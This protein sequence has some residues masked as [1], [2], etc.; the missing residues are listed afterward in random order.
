MRSDRGIA[1]LL[2]PSTA[3]ATA[4]DPTIRRCRGFA[5]LWGCAGITVAL[6]ALRAT[7]AAALWRHSDPKGPE[8]DAWLLRLTTPVVLRASAAP[9]FWFSRMPP[10]R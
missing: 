2:N 3:D 8:N 10:F 4:D 7:D 1:L 9:A 6:Y 5:R